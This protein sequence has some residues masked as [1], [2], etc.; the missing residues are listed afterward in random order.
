M[1]RLTDAVTPANLDAKNLRPGAPAWNGDLT[2]LTNDQLVER[3]NAL[4]THLGNITTVYR[5]SPADHWTWR[6]ATPTELADREQ[7]RWIDARLAAL[8]ERETRLASTARAVP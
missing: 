4:G 2:S 7:S 1:D 8:R 3:I 5:Y 6:A